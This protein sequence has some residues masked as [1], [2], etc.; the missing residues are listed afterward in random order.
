MLTMISKNYLVL[1]ILF[2]NIKFIQRF[3]L[4]LA[5]STDHKAREPPTH[6]TIV[7]PICGNVYKIYVSNCSPKIPL[8]TGLHG[9]LFSS[10]VHFPEY[11]EEDDC[12]I[13]LPESFSAESNFIETDSSNEE[14]PDEEIS[15][16]QQKG[17]GRYFDNLKKIKVNKTPF[18]IDRKK[19]SQV[20]AH[21]IAKLLEKLE[22]GRQWKKDIRTTWSD[23]KDIRYRDCY[24]GYTCPNVDCN[25]LLQF[26]KPNKV[27]FEKDGTC[28]TCSATDKKIHVFRIRACRT[29]FFLN[30]HKK[31]FG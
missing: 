6:D 27:N 8:T 25:Y 10:N 19:V 15:Y 21:T 4:I 14:A 23:F 11:N 9:D 16:R 31:C 5:G 26:G 12:Y 30:C 28:K 1:S 18:D 2:V 22:D 13:T 24:G 17:F 7:C 29:L 3:V 20:T